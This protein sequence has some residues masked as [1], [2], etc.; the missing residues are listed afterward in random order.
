[1]I[2]IQ[3][4]KADFTDYKPFATHTNETVVQMFLGKG[5]TGF[6]KEI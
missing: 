3:L 6:E 2:V 4:M 5:R 1:M